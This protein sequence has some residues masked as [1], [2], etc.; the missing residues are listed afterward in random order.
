[1]VKSE[2][3]SSVCGHSR[4]RAPTGPLLLEKPG[5]WRSCCSGPA[6]SQLLGV[7]QLASTRGSRERDQGRQ[8]PRM[9]SPPPKKIA[10][11]RTVS[12]DHDRET[13]RLDQASRSQ[14]VRFSRGLQSQRFI[15]VSRPT[16]PNVATAQGPGCRG[17]PRHPRPLQ[18]CLVVSLVEF[19]PGDTWC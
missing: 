1:M 9:R 10:C 4:A 6:R 14:G 19:P 5:K 15:S 3:L 13:L 8:G 18:A 7:A 17:A 12:R 2:T 11:R 16:D